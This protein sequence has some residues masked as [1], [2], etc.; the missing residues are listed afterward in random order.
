L[1]ALWRKLDALLDVHRF[2]IVYPVAPERRIVRVDAAGEITSARRSSR[3]ATV[4]DVIDEL[5]AS[6][7]Y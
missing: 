1:S 7:R 4:V 5:V 3:R 2:G 6:H